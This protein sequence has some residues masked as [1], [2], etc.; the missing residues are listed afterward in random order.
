M[1]QRAILRRAFPVFLL[2]STGIVTRV[3]A[4]VLYSNLQGNYLSQQVGSYTLSVPNNITATTTSGFGTYYNTGYDQISLTSFS[5]YGGTGELAGTPPGSYGDG[6][7]VY[8][9]DASGNF[10]GPAEYSINAVGS[11]DSGQGNGL[12]TYSYNGS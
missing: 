1:M 11:S 6:L 10:D 9:F 12:H 2:T 5:F 8:F 7:T 4:D 3:H